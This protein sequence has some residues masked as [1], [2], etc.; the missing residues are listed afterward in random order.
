MIVCK[1]VADFD[2]EGD[3]SG[4]FNSLAPLGAILCPDDA[5]FFASA[6]D[7][8]DKKKVK[9]IL[10]KNGYEDS[11]IVEYGV[12]NPPKETPSIN[13]W[14]FDYITQNAIIRLG[15]DNRD[16]IRE[17]IHQL[18]EIDELVAKELVAL[19]KGQEEESDTEQSD[20]ITEE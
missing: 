16:A 20:N 2:S 7:R 5:L 14:V 8:I 1:I 17:G 15:K 10:K 6:L 4:L 19:D 11:V 3:F 9:R 18:D 13:G 12:N